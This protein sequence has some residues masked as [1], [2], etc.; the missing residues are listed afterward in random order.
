MDF[1]GDFDA[2]GHFQVVFGEDENA[3]VACSYE[4]PIPRHNR[5]V[6]L[7]PLYIQRL[8]HALRINPINID[9]Q[10]PVISDHQFRVD[11]VYV[12]DVFLGQAVDMSGS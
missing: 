2:G 6:H 7:T 4:H 5:A 11:R 1:F 10:R 9:I 12:F 8:Q 3:A